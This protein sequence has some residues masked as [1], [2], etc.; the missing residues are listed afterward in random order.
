MGSPRVA[1]SSI[2]GGGIRSSSLSSGEKSASPARWCAAAATGYSLA[3]GFVL[4]RE[5]DPSDGFSVAL[6]GV[7]LA[8]T[9]LLAPVRMPERWTALLTP[10]SLGLVATLTGFGAYFLTIPART[11]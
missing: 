6:A 2:L 9:L 8:L 4:L 1:R 5:S 7:F 11:W 10:V 3:A